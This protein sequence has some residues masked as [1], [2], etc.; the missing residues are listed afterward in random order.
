M[1]KFKLNDLFQS[2]VSIST[3]YP[4]NKI[5]NINNKQYANRHPPH[6]K[7]IHIL[8]LSLAHSVLLSLV[9]IKLSRI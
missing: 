9:M 8:T 4:S 1:I 5:I 2:F 6:P 3:K 7:N